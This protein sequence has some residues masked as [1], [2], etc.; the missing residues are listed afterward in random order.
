MRFLGFAVVTGAAIMLG[1]CGGDKAATTD[2]AMAPA[3]DTTAMAPAAAP[4][5]AGAMAPITGTTHEVKMIGDGAGYRFEPANLTIAA[6]DGVKFILVSGGPHNVAFDPAVVPAAGKTQLMANM[7]EQSG[8]LSGKM[9]LN[10]DE[11]YTVSFGGV[12]AGEYAFHCTPHLAM[13]MKGVITVK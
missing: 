7:P 1:A 4:A 12:A 10:A 11:S 3:A 8:E 6:G 9:M 5:A 13:N 2:S